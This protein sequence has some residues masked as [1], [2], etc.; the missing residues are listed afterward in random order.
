MARLDPHAHGAGLTMQA[1]F[2]RSALPYWEA[3]APT[4]K[5]V[6]PLAPAESD[7]RYYEARAACNIPDDGAAMRA[8]LLGVTA[9]IAAMRWPA[10]TRLVSLDWAEGMIRHVWPR[11]HVPAHAAA[12]RGD[13]REMPLASG[14]LDFVVGDGC[15]SVFADLAGPAAM[16]REVHRV[17]RRDGEFC[18]RCFR[19]PDTPASIE[20]L[21]VALFA[22][23]FPNLDLFRWL[24]AMAVQGDSPAGVSVNAV[25]RVWRSHVPDVQ[26]HRER[27]GWSAEALANME[28]WSRMETRY[29]FPTLAELRALADEHFTLIACDFPG[30]EWGEQFPRLVMKRS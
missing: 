3:R 28:R 7:V 24:L 9:P 27:L 20:E 17:L 26:A 16:N 10:A 11:E 5:V 22:G 1:T 6:P 14:A 29:T 15:Y 21:F 12:L 13:W 19:R 23:R 8:L 25:W 30:Y 18:L 4:W 2:D